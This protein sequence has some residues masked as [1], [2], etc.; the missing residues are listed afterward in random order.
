[1]PVREL[2][3]KAERLLQAAPHLLTDSVKM[4]AHHIESSLA[5]VIAPHL[6][7]APDEARAVLA[8]FMNLPGSFHR[9]GDTVVVTLATAAAPRYTRAL[10]ALCEHVNELHPVF[11]ETTTPMFFRV[12]LTS[13]QSEQLKAAA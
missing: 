5:D 6:L 12:R 1:V 8:D 10:I 7:R 11:P 2:A 3:P 4:V 13:L 9:E